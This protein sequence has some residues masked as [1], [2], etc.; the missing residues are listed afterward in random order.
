MMPVALSMPS[1]LTVAMDAV[2][3]I[4]KSWFCRWVKERARRLLPVLLPASFIEDDARS[5][6]GLVTEA[7]PLIIVDIL[8]PS[9][10]RCFRYALIVTA[11]FKRDSSRQSKMDFRRWNGDGGLFELKMRNEKEPVGV[12]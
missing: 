4:G 12:M 11:A 10:L 9:F 3:P 7:I 1:E 8:L 6:M 5:M 2:L